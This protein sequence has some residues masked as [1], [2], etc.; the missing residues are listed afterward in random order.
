LDLAEGYSSRTT[1]WLQT[2]YEHTHPITA[3][4]YAAFTHTYIH[5][6]SFPQFYKA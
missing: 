2:D 4:H 6:L 3:G 1:S 5:I